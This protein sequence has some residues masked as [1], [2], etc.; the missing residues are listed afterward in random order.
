MK[1]VFGKALSGYLNKDISTYIV[2]R[3]DGFGEPFNIGTYFNE[4]SEWKEHEKE[5]IK[6]AS[7]RILDIGAGAGRHAL[8]FQ[9]KGLEVHA[10]DISPS[11][12]KVMR[13]RGIKNVYLMD[14]KKM[15][16]PENYF[17]S[18]LMMFN[19]FGLAGSI[20][21]T[22]KLLKILYKISVP[23][24]KIIATIRNPYKTDKP[25]HLS[26]QEK[27]IKAGRPAG[28]I[29]IRI[30]YKNE[31][32]NWFKILMVSPDELKKLIQSTG[33]KILKIAEGPDGT[34][35]AVLEK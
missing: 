20:A 24:G 16:F 17:D 27:N 23:K 9:N 3:D 32:G 28:L 30:E 26:Y 31:I 15:D 21:G 29:R 18:I 33:W 13:K 10:V 5:I 1:D 6:Y 22:K 11:A 7:G 12:I 25:E 4:Y 8:Y 2:R 19:N 34:Y 35:G 14:L